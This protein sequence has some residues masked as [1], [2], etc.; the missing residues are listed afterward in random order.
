MSPTKAH[1]DLHD[2]GIIST[3]KTF[4]PLDYPALFKATTG[5]T[6]FLLQGTTPV[7]AILNSTDLYLFLRVYKVQFSQQRYTFPF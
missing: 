2:G 3:N 4:W 7:T 6:T 1:T 5:G